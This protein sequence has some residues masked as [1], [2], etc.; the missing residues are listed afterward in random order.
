MGFRGVFGSVVAAVVVVA[1]AAKCSQDP[2]DASVAEKFGKGAAEA[3]G[4]AVSGLAKGAAN[5]IEKLGN[6]LSRDP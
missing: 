3:T 2:S 5:Y 1:G 4:D 6:E